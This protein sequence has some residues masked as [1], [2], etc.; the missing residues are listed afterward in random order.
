MKKAITSG[1][2]MSRS[3][4]KKKRKKDEIVSSGEALSSKQSQREILSVRVSMLV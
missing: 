2:S 1:M 4:K 3:E